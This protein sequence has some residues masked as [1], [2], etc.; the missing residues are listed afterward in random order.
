MATT[1]TT[2]AVAVRALT[3][4]IDDALAVPPATCPPPI[5]CECAESESEVEALGSTYYD[6]EQA[7]IVRKEA[8]DPVRRLIDSVS[9]CKMLSPRAERIS[10][11]FSVPAFLRNTPDTHSGLLSRRCARAQLLRVAPLHLLLLKV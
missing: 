9:A 7:A 1:T 3:R 4:A 10:L 5:P 8:K 11:K 6:S 2:S